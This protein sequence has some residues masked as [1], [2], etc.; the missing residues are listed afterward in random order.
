MTSMSMCGVRTED[1]AQ[2]WN[3]SK[4]HIIMTVLIRDTEKVFA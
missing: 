1:T 4:Q 2:L 3:I